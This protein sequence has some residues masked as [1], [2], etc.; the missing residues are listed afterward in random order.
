MRDAGVANWGDADRRVDAEDG[1]VNA[2]DRI[3]DTGGGRVG[4][5]DRSVGVAGGVVV[6]IRVLSNWG[7]NL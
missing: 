3:I 5:A 2:A 1:R 4:A 7:S 6:G